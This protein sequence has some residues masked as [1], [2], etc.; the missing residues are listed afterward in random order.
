MDNLPTTITNLLFLLPISKAYHHNDYL[1]ASAISAVGTASFISHLVENHKHGMPGMI[2]VSKNT[3]YF[4]NRLDIFGCVIVALRFGY[5][6]I[7]NWKRMR[8]S[9]MEVILT[10]SALI[11]NMA[12]EYD[13]HNSRL[14][15]CLYIPL[16]SIWHI[17]AAMLMNTF[18]NKI[19]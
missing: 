17:M 14:K 6:F 1:T 12:S 11:C 2:D 7:T 4:L 15:Y 3:S 18:L 5:I 8:I 9:R 19:Y 10:L 16:H 13:K